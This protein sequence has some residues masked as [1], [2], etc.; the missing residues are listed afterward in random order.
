[1]TR[2]RMALTIIAAFVVAN[3][4]ATII[5][6]FLLAAD[7]APYYGS[8]LRGG[9]EPPV[10]MLLLPVAHLCFI[11][12]L[13]W[14]YARL[15]LTGSLPVQGL[16]IGLLGWLVGQG[17]LWMVWYAEQPWPGILFAKQLVLELIAASIVGVTI[18][19]I[20]GREVRAPSRAT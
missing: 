12:G 2:K 10:Q 19:L 7:Y 16:K 9:D 18:A 1:M 13:V 17:P 20:A 3:L 4:L 15:P 5:H 8:L 14:I 11:V 6:G